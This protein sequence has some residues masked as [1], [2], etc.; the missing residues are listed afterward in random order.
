MPGTD[1]GIGH[2]TYHS[3]ELDNYK[4]KNDLFVNELVLSRY[5]SNS[6]FLSAHLVDH[7]NDK[8]AYSQPGII[9]TVD[10][11]TG[12]E[13]TIVSEVLYTENVNQKYIGFSINY[14]KKWYIEPYIGTGLFVIKNNLKQ[15]AEFYNENDQS[16]SL[17]R[18]SEKNT[19]SYYSNLTIGVKFYIINSVN[20]NANLKYFRRHLYEFKHDFKEIGVSLGYTF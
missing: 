8:L 1:I 15:T 11:V 20:I 6:I 9:S 19:Y 14:S 3:N 2:R 4:F 5:L 10:A 13:S 16:L 7:G 12:L 17:L 18:S